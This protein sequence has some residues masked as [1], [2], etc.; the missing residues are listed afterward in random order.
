[1][2]LSRFFITRPIFAAVIAIVI[3]IIGAI[4]YLGLPVSQ[5][6]D[7]VPP[8]VTVSAS[9]PGASAETVADT[10]AAPLEQEINGVDNMLY[11]SSQSTGDGRVTIT[12]TFKIGTNLDEAQVLVQNRVGIAV[13]RL[14]QEVQRLGVVTRKTSP[15]FLMVV[16][17]VSP[18]KSLDRAYISN[19]ALTQI[20]DKLTRIDGVGDVQMFGSRD[21]AMRI[22]IDPSR[23]AALNLTAGEIVAALRAQNVQVAAGTLGQ[24]PYSTGN[25]FQVNVET[26]GRL[27]DPAEFGAV[28]IRTDADGRQV[29]VSD[30]ARVELGAADYAS[31]T[32]ISGEDTVILP[33]F[34]RPGSNALGAANAVL[35]EMETLSKSFPKGLE[36][37]VIYNPTE[38]ISQSIDAVMKTLLEAIFLVVLVIVVFL[39]KWRAAIIP[40]VAIP[41]SLIGT[42]AVLAA[43]GYSINNLSLFGLVLAI[44]IVV[45][46]AIVVVENVERNLARGLSP[47]EAART[48]MDEVSGA[49]VAIVLV[50]CAVFIPTLFLAGLSG[51][52]YQ[53]FAV[54]ISTATVISL[55]LSLTLSPALAAVLL[56]GHAE[57]QLGNRYVRMAQ[58]AG[59]RFNRGF[60]RM[61]VAY[62][63]LTRRLVQRPK[64]MMVT[65]VGLIAATLGLFW[66][67]PSGFIPAQDQGYFLTIIQLPPGASVER[68][69]A[70]MRKVAQR[71]LPLKGIKG[72]IMLAGFDGPSQT[73]APNAAAAYF[74]LTSFE[75]RKALGLSFAGIMAEAGNATADIDE[76]RLMIVPPP[77]IQ[78]I[79]SAGGY[80]LM[81]QDRA[82]NGYQKLAAESYK[83]IGKANQTEGL[84]QAYTFFDTATPRIFADIDRRKAD[85][86]GVPP[87]RVFEALQ[88]YLGS[89]FV[90]DF[91]LLGRTYR[92]TAQADA[93]FRASEADIANLKTRS[94][95]GA[96]VP[97]GSVSTFKDQTGP[98]RV[99][100]YN[101]FPAVEVDGDTAPGYSSGQALV[102]ME[103]LAAETLSSG[104]TSE[105]TGIAFQQKA[106]GNTAAIVFALA[107]LF[108]FL[109]LA[110]QYES[111]VLPLAIILIV[112]MCLLAAMIGI[113]LRGMDNNVLTQIGLVVLIALAAKNAILVVEFA[114]QA[115]EQDGLSPIEAAVRAAQD[116]L[117]PIL[118]T[119]FAFI[120]GTVPLLIASGAGAE[121]RQALGTA[122]FFGMIGV[123]GFGLLFT[124]T[125]YVVCRALGDRLRRRK[126][127]SASAPLVQPAE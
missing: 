9:Y 106:A 94:N 60:E 113:N 118:M 70:V 114:K 17:L 100:R 124:P 58:R 52:F 53:Q 49:L 103:K 101:L 59:D 72:A 95:S 90:N 79:G 15:D 50:L 105:W 12:V 36:Y 56:K 54:T 57:E 10:V 31:N 46:D 82:G 92:V 16:N 64:R 43:V 61:S 51:A 65:Y 89:A 19:Y 4:A 119:S 11:V 37:R 109:V 98:Y 32:Y 22:W 87:E 66:V 14:P 71:I 126:P 93:P 25:A 67:T 5:Y 73:L 85:M 33:I 120:L 42:F 108:V 122:V 63:G 2:R 34:Q 111:V 86:L 62:A 104:Y 117:R 13:P 7:I 20:R 29:R 75:D 18:D 127:G 115:E 110:A 102:T 39:Q 74:P 116:R 107:V 91:N 8:T 84:A 123:T 125:F 45:D 35:A 44:G 24:P 28:V 21:Y 48:S 40:V 3:T 76:A 77:L 55:I 80:R 88:I 6:P 83:L 41:V 1:M 30:V 26:Q 27:K 68:T 81:V 121:L 112:P 38:F 99:V 97:I 47:L 78:G 96:M 23:A 69:D